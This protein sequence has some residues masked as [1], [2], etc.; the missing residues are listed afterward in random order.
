[1]NRNE[2]VNEYP[3]QDVSL[4]RPIPSLTTNTNSR[5]LSLLDGRPFFFQGIKQI[6]KP[7]AV[8]SGIKNIFAEYIRY[9]Y[10]KK[11]DDE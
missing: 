6:E 8:V 1:M 11:K 9:D 3:K 4:A 10:F 5:S 2:P 7:Y